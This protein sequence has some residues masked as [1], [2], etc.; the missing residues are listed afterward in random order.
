MTA[1]ANAIGFVV[2]DMTAAVAFY[3]LLG[4]EFPGDA[5]D[6]RNTELAPGFE[7]MLDSEES[8]QPFS[9][10]WESP[11]GSPRS[12]LAFEFDTPADVDAKYAELVEAGAATL[13]EPWD[14]FWGQRYA[15]ITDPD[16]NG[17][18][19]YAALPKD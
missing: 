3:G 19:L 2:S 11:S 8:I 6:H 10:R 18:D 5:A 16:G 15:S 1:K 9:P 12:A 13:R 4:L 14:A 17:I 7:L